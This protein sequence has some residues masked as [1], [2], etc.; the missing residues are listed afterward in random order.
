MATELR[1]QKY[2]AKRL[3]LTTT[4]SHLSHR[5]TTTPHR[6]SLRCPQFLCMGPTYVEHTVIRKA[7]S[8][9]VG[10]TVTMNRIKNCSSFLFFYLLL[11]PFGQ[12]NFSQMPQNLNV[13]L[14]NLLDAV[15]T[16]LKH[17]YCLSLR[18]THGKSYNGPKYMFL[19]CFLPNWIC[20]CDKIQKCIKAK[21]QWIHEIPKTR[22]VFWLRPCQN[23]SLCVLWGHDCYSYIQSRIYENTIQFREFIERTVHADAYWRALAAEPR[24][25][26]D[27]LNSWQRAGVAWL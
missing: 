18:V 19:G 24:L 2:I 20:P 4:W 22:N 5:R 1:S 26:R 11:S 12:N 7:T 16:V 10:E 9:I 15:A 8:H 23:G 21:N 14:Y 27:H 25:I 13:W 6:L 3:S 17:T